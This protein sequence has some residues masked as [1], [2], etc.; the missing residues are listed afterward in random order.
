MAIALRRRR[1]SCATNTTRRPNAC[2]RPSG[3]TSASAA[4][5]SRLWTAN[6]CACFIR[7]SSAA[8]AGRIF[9]ARCCK[10]ATS[11]RASG[12]V[13]IDIRASGWH[14]HGHDRNPAFHNVH[15]PRRLGR[16]PQVADTPRCCRCAIPSTRRSGE[17]SLWL[18]S[19]SSEALPECQRGRC[20]APLCDLSK[21]QLTEL[22]CHAAQVR[23]QAKA[24]QFQARAR[25][26]GWE[27]ALLGRVVPRARLQAQHLADAMP[28]R[29]TRT[30]DQQK[31]AAA[32][33]AGA[34]VR[35]QRPVACRIEPVAEPVRT[36]ICAASGTSGGAN[37]RN[38]AIAS[39]RAPRGNSMACVR[40]TIR[41]AVWHWQ[42]TGSPPAV[43]PRSLNAGPRAI[44]RTTCCRIHSTRFFKWG[45]MSFG[46][47]TGRS[48]RRG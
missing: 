14:A 16:R 19:E 24:A 26:A 39:C 27:Q 37:G 9:A 46:R 44:S 33:V 25:Q 15:P 12:D 47:G 7:V 48:V 2:C 23:F 41:N 11:R 13:E 10:S 30:L 6:P 4:T 28:G 20:A 34:T 21:A 35:H 40:Q 36:V 1:P 43:C 8:K 45:V 42:R 3:N 29:N 38:S 31:S 18:E 32:R 5:G 17:L 22:L